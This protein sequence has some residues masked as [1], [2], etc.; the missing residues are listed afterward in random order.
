MLLQ[1]SV[2]LQAIN[3]K[4]RRF[5]TA[6]SELF[7][8]TSLILNTAKLSK[9]LDGAVGSCGYRVVNALGTATDLL[10]LFLVLD[11]FIFRQL[12]KNVVLVLC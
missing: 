6:Q 8:F 7:H 12:C 9:Y 3:L 2:H 1:S 5:L 4:S 11:F 10:Y